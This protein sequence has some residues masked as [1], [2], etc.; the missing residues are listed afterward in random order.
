[1][2][3]CLER[4]S[5]VI[6][7]RVKQLSYLFIVY[8]SGNKQEKSDTLLTCLNLIIWNPYGT[9]RGRH[10]NNLISLKKTLLK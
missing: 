8:S 6:F 2:N 7:D 1:M 5:I 9:P 4:L 3:V 10:C